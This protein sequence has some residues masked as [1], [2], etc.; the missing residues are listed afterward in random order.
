MEIN[1]NYA[2]K[3]KFDAYRLN[4]LR[5]ELEVKFDI[6]PEIKSEFKEL[7]ELINAATK[8]LKLHRN[9]SK[10][11][12]S[13]TIQRIW[14]YGETNLNDKDVID[15]STTYKILVLLIGCQTLLEFCQRCD[16]KKG[17][18]I[19]DLNPFEH[20][21]TGFNQDS[22]KKGELITVGFPPKKYSILECQT[23]QAFEVIY[24][25]PKMANKIGV[26]IYVEDFFL[27]DSNLDKDGFPDIKY[28]YFPC[29][30]ECHPGTNK[31]IDPL[32]EEPQ[33]L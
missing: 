5:E 1:K 29:D 8:D 24:A 13:A 27:D 18:P 31:L 15:R 6:R 2:E 32:F 10:T 4:V 9:F 21:F 26:T 33:F 7:T 25:T 3:I 20:F 30:E 14:G 19:Q 12:S 28:N 16:L 17:M 23:K 11:I 22:I